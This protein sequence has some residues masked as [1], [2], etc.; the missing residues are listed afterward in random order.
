MSNYLTDFFS[1]TQEQA[2]LLKA[3]SF[4]RLDVGHLIEELETMGAS[5]RRELL[6]RLEELLP[7]LLKWR[8]Q[9]GLRGASWEVS[10]IKQRDA[11]DDLFEA[12]PS[13]RPRLNEVFDKAYR[14]ARVYASKET[15]LALPTFPES[16]AWTVDEVLRS[17]FWPV[18]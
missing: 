18:E 3:G 5:E 10:I 9:P 6:S 14:R 7:H 8:Y 4:D 1:W 13:L 12:S 2:A 15:G 17:N 16:C 11:L